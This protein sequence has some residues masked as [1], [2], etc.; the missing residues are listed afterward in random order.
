MFISEIQCPKTIRAYQVVVDLDASA[1]QPHTE[2]SVPVW[3]WESPS[4][5]KA[6]CLSYADGAVGTEEAPFYS[7]LVP[8]ARM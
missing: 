8:P 1:P 6:T 2:C 4:Q 5:E 3:E 7:T